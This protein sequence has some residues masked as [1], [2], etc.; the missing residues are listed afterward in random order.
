MKR[1][2]RVNISIQEKFPSII[3]VYLNDALYLVITDIL[4]NSL[5]E[6]KLKNWIKD[7]YSG[8]VYRTKNYM[9]PEFGPKLF[10]KGEPLDLKDYIEKLESLGVIEDKLTDMKIVDSYNE[11]KIIDYIDFLAEKNGYFLTNKEDYN[12]KKYLEKKYEEIEL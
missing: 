6:E 5:D 12:L 9:P 11:S 4:R 10:C 2:E 8:E 1:L 3:E 7:T